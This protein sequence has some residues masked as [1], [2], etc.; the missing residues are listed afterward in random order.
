LKPGEE[1][2]HVAYRN[3]DG[4]NHNDPI[5]PA[6]WGTDNMFFGK[7]FYGDDK[8]GYANYPVY[9]DDPNA[10]AFVEGVKKYPENITD[11]RPYIKQY[12]DYLAKTPVDQQESA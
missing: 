6:E 11:L 12:E 10:L 3:I 9:A 4:P 7:P 8:V 2:V 5:L 1:N